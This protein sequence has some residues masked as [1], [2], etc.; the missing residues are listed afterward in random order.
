MALNL[1]TKCL[2]A[3][4]PATIAKTIPYILTLGPVP[5][6]VPAP[7]KCTWPE[8]LSSPGSLVSVASSAVVRKVCLGTCPQLPPNSSPGGRSVQPVAY[9]LQVSGM[10][11]TFSITF[12]VP[13]ESFGSAYF[14]LVCDRGSRTRSN[15]QAENQRH[16]G[17][18][19]LSPNTKLPMWDLDRT[20]GPLCSG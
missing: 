18:G 4:H 7:T 17:A 3:L 5:G 19:H 14:F 16:W 15:Q 6:P 13:G 12:H 1:S 11:F 9:F 2:V 8:S 10:G 20:H